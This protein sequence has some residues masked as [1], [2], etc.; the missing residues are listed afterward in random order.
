MSG[1]EPGCPGDLRRNGNSAVV[2]NR[3]VGAVTKLADVD[4]GAIDSTMLIGC[5]GGKILG[6]ALHAF[7]H[8]SSLSGDVSASV[9]PEGQSEAYQSAA[10]GSEGPSG[11]EQGVPSVMSD[12]ISKRAR[13]SHCSF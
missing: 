9:Q 4:R 2:I 5:A 13:N 6:R 8:A 1:C 12:S 7:T 11:G 10:N 3:R